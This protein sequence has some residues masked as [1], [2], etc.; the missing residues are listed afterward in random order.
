MQTF[1]EEDTCKVLCVLEHCSPFVL[2][3]CGSSII[4]HRD[5]GGNSS[6][7]VVHVSGPEVL[8]YRSTTRREEFWLI[9]HSVHIQLLHSSRSMS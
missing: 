4:D 1:R 2:R 5:T 6:G 3:A 7:G 8:S 9:F